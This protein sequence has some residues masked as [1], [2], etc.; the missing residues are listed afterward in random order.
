MRT[1]IRVLV[2]KIPKDGYREF[3]RTEGTH[4]V[5]RQRNIYVHAIEN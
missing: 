5:F 3:L 2:Q 1:F 4:N